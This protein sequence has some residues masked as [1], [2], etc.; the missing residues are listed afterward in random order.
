MEKSIHSIG[1]R[2]DKF[3]TVCDR[4]CGHV[5]ATL[6][7]KERISMVACPRCGTRSRYSMKADIVRVK[8]S[9]KSSEVYSGARTYRVGQWM[10]HQAYGE[11]EVT[12]LVEPQKIDVL[13]SDRLRRLIH[14]RVAA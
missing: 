9:G 12:A 5:I 11:G 10:T 2:I 14:S 1:E 6:S 4:A 3:C 8:A 7:K 13:F